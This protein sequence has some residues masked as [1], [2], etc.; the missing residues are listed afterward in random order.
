MAETIPMIAWWFLDKKK[1]FETEQKYKETN[2]KIT[3]VLLAQ[4][5]E[6]SARQEAERKEEQERQARK[7]AERREKQER[8]AREQAELRE[9]QER[10]ARENSEH[11]EAQ[12]RLAREE[13]ESREEQERLARNLAEAREK[14]ERIAREQAEQREGQERLARREAEQ[15]EKQ[16]RL[17]RQQAECREEQERLARREAELREEQGRSALELAQL[18]ERLAREAE[19]KERY[20]RELRELGVLPDRKITDADIK[21]ARAVAGYEDGCVNIALIGSQGT[22]KSSLIN[23]L[24]GLS[25][26]DRDAAEVGDIETTLRRK[27]YRDSKSIVWYDIPGSGTRNVSAWQYYYDNDLYIYDKIVFVHGKILTESDLRI[28]KLCQYRKQEWVSVRSKADLHIWSYKRRRGMCPA[29]ARQCY[30]DAV[31]SDTATYN[32]RDENSVEDLKL[33]VKDY[34]VSD[35]GVLQLVTGSE[36][37]EDPIEQVI[38]EAAFLEDLGLS[39]GRVESK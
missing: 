4:E 35:M 5:Q 16:E 19:R 11:R 36:P 20:E 33:S 38:D 37:S 10:L 22:G 13:A 39:P 31:R 1:A 21:Y 23:S 27:K 34:I 17:A 12:E 7:E 14:E 24:R 9:D 3:E 25:H 32:A 8:I 29:E 15:R 30:I 2:K 26:G 18:N 6:R 28:L